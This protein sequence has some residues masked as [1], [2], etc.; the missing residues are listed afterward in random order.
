MRPFIK[1]RRAEGST[2]RGLIWLVGGLLALHFS[3]D[4]A[5][6]MSSLAIIIGG[7]GG[8]LTPDRLRCPHPDDPP[9]E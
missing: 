3:A 5:A 2:L 8:M 1:A 6:V 9:S 4:Q 7:A